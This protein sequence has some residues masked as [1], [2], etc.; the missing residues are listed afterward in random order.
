[1]NA[2]E[3]KA[4]LE[5]VSD[6]TEILI[7]GKHSYHTCRAEEGFAGD[8]NQYGQAQVSVREDEE[9]TPVVLL[10]STSTG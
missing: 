7:E 2:G 6:D 4:F 9:D 8:I 10:I 5:D 1:M 3:L